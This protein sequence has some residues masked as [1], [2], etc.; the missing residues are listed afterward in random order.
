[1]ERAFKGIWIPKEI[2]L[3]NELTLQE[4]VFLAEISSLDN[5]DGCFASN[6]YFSEFF[7]LSKNRCSE[8]IKSLEKKKLISVKYIREDGKKNIQK[9]VLKVIEKPNRGIRNIDRSIREIEEGYS[10]NCEDNNTVINNTTNNTKEIYIPFAEFV[11]MKQSEYDKLVSEHGKTLTNKMIEVL[12]NY[13]GANGKKYKS[14]YRA[15]LNWVRDKV[16]NERGVAN[17]ANKRSSHVA[18]EYGIPF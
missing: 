16:L 13:K 7:N 2:W 1:M 8:V 15:I 9:R 5:K 18:E 17:G 4:K 6:T 14:D 10:E 12:D 11:K 3:S